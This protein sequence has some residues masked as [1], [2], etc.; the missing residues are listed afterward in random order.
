VGRAERRVLG[1]YGVRLALEDIASVWRI[2]IVFLMLERRIHRDVG[3]RSSEL[4]DL[5]SP[6]YSLVRQVSV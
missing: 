1:Q 5:Y 3:F 4:L 6:A 2:G